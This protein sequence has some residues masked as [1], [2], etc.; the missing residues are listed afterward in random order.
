[1]KDLLESEDHYLSVVI[2]KLSV[3]WSFALI[4]VEI[5][6]HM[7]GISFSVKYTVAVGVL[8]VP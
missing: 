3:C 7:F 5:W 6:L 1:M 4:L 2:P 8:R